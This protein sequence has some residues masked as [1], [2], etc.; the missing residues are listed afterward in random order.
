MISPAY[1]STLE[2]VTSLIR[3]TRRIWGNSTCVNSPVIDLKPSTW[4]DAA[5]ATWN[6]STN[7]V[8]VFDDISVVPSLSN[9]CKSND[10]AMLNSLKGKRMSGAIKSHLGLDWLR[11]SFWNYCRSRMTGGELLVQV[12]PAQSIPRKVKQTKSDHQRYN[13]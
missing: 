13:S 3:H 4:L 11:H 2:T 9:H 8:D 7:Q 1:K 10:R 12:I 5:E 6:I